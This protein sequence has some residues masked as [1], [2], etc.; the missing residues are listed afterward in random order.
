MQIRLLIPVGLLLATSAT[1]ANALIT[2]EGVG[3]VEYLVGFAVLV[4]LLLSAFGVSRR[5][6]R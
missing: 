5:A 4:V 3:V 2:K 6:L 1:L